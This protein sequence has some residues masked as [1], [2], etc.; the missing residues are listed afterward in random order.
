MITL[1]IRNKFLRKRQ[2]NNQFKQII[3]SNILYY[4]IYQCYNKDTFKYIEIFFHKKSI[5]RESNPWKVSFETDSLHHLFQI[6][7]EKFR[8][9]SLA[10]INLNT[11][12]I[13]FYSFNIF[14]LCSLF[15][16]S[17]ADIKLK[18]I[19]EINEQQSIISYNDN[20]LN[21]IKNNENIYIDIN[22]NN[23]PFDLIKQLKKVNTK[24]IIDINII[25]NFLIERLLKEKSSD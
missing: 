16:I 24:F 14:T 5:K 22:P 3:K 11:Y 10:K 1:V 9:C 25:I 12:S 6:I 23:F 13:R 15:Y 2:I 8:D 20:V 4:D 19:N 7:A 18:F 21:I 17:W